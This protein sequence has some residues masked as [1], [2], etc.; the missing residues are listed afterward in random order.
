MNPEGILV[1]NKPAGMT[2]HDVILKVR[3]ML[4]TKKVGHTGTLDPDVTGVLPLCIGRA[5]KLVEYLQEQ[6]KT[7]IAEWTAGIATDTEDRS[8][9]VIEKRED[10]R[11]DLQDV[12]KIFHSFVGTYEQIPPMY[13][14][15][16][17]AGKK[18][19]ELARL[20]EVV[21]RPK[22]L[23]EIYQLE[24]LEAHLNEELPRVRFKVRCSKGTYVRTLCV[25]LG[26]A[27]NVP[28]HMSDLIRVESAGY[29]L[30]N[31]HS[32]EE[33]EQAVYDRDCEKLLV[34]ID[35]ALSN[36]PGVIVPEHMVA[37]I[38]NGQAIYPRFPLPNEFNIGENVRILSPAG[39]LLAI[40]KVIKSEEI[41]SKPKKILSLRE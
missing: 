17:I 15:V 36:F 37:R 13:S 24:I 5:T 10:V 21:E 40:H 4:K 25:D 31:A 14:A 23:V 34:P 12:T 22:R 41:W 18:L 3:K 32:L 6:P 11:L 29:E 9:V 35:S 30:H 39:K 19:Y 20:G 1:V 28:A 7:Y 38:Q 2:S 8:G 16:K 33:I 26:K 27:L